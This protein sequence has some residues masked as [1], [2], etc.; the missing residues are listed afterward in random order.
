MA[1]TDILRKRHKKNQKTKVLEK[2]SVYD[3]IKKPLL[4]EKTYK[5]VSD[6]KDE[7]NKNFVYTFIVDSEAN[8]NDIKVAIK[9]L[10]NVD[11][12][13]VRTLR[14]TQKWRT[15]RKVVRHAYKKAIVTLQKWQ[16]IE[17]V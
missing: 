9:Q 14:T 1:F 11:V 6:Q 13:W 16:K 8:K 10:Y 5:Q 15:Q 3:I 17:L 12:V 2:F 7:K 4:T